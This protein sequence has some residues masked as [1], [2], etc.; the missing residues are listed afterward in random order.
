[1]IKAGII[2]IIAEEKNSLIIDL[3]NVAEKI[4]VDEN[5]K[6]A[7]D[8]FN[9]RRTPDA[10]QMLK[11]IL[12]RL[13]L[14]TDAPRIF[15]ARVEATAFGVRVIVERFVEEGVLVKIV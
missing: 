13:N 12:S 6:S 11:G 3:T 7:L 4:R 5:T 8:W 1:M 10:G 15:R 2:P 14:G 9:G